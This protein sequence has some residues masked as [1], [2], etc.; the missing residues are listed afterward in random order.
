LLRPLCD[1]GRAQ[2]RALSASLEASGVERILSSPALRCRQTLAPLAHATGIPIEIDERLA[3]GGDEA[4][5]FE[6][7]AA[8]RDRATALC[9]H[10]DA[11]GAVL[12]TPARRG[13]R[14]RRGTALREGLRVTIEGSGARAEIAALRAAGSR[15]SLTRTPQKPT[16]RFGI[17]DLGSTSFHLLVATPTPTAT[18][19]R[20][21]ASA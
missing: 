11:I 21:C 14:G 15:A 3:E 8:F 18:S 12:R 2:A 16:I 10:G 5:L 17:L 19:P 6:A 4:K 13:T 1:A 7:I 9:T 20:S